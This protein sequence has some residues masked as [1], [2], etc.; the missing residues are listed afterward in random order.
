MYFADK[1]LICLAIGI[2]SW[3]SLINSSTHH[4]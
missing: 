3:A 2:V 4:V 1:I